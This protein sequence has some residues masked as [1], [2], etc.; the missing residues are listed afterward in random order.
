MHDCSAEGIVVVVAAVAMVVV[1]SNFLRP[2]LRA[3][4]WVVALVPSPAHP[5][6]PL[7]SRVVV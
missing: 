7:Y 5:D 2:R 4:Y 1:V 6:T 3:F